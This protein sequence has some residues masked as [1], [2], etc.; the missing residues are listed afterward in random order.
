MEQKINNIIARV[1]SETLE[2][3]AFLFTFAD[4]EREGDGAGPGIVGR[5]SFNGFFAGSLLVRMSYSG[6]QE[7]VVNML[8]LDDDDE[9][10]SDEKEDAFKEMLNVI[11]GNALPAI[12]GNQVEFS[13]GPPE[14]ISESAF[15][16][17]LNE[18]NPECIVR[19]ML[20]EGICDVYFFVDGLLPELS[21]ETHSEE[22]Q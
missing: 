9:I 19:L 2:K 3:L 18:N 20:E 4:D 13:I 5:V 11:C 6:L 16:I 7:L 1:V 12:A 10:S 21:L 17:A 8:G 22:I 14:I 15:G